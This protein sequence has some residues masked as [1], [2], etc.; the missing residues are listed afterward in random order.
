MPTVKA[1]TVTVDSLLP[2]LKLDCNV[3]YDATMKGV[4]VV[5]KNSE[6]FNLQSLQLI[7]EAKITLRTASCIKKLNEAG[8]LVGWRKKASQ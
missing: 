4:S 5:V 7:R 2:R 6:F 3:G 1:M 8:N